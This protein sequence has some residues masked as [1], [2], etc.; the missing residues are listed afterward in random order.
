MLPVPHMMKSYL[1][2]LAALRGYP[3]K[4]SGPKMLL[5]YLASYA[6]PDGSQIEPGLGRITEETALAK[7]SAIK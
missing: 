7:A 4:P 1:S 2:L 3:L 6:D 5:M